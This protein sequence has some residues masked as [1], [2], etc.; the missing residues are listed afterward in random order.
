[1]N[2]APHCHLRDAD[3]FSEVMVTLAYRSLDDTPLGADHYHIQYVEFLDFLEALYY[4]FERDSDDWNRKTNCWFIRTQHPVH[5]YEKG[6]TSPTKSELV[7]VKPVWN[8]DREPFRKL[9]GHYRWR[10]GNA[11]QEETNAEVS[12]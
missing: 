1:M 4:L 7:D 10:S 9:L 12:A 6:F 3:T 11:S 2:K 5:H 8:T